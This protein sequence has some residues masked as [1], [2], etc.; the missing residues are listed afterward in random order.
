MSAQTLFQ[1]VFPASVSVIGLL[2]YLSA[3]FI[4]LPGHSMPKDQLELPLSH[5]RVASGE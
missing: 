2:A 3:R 4:L 5:Q 1:W